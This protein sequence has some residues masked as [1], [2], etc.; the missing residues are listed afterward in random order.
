MKSRIKLTYKT[1]DDIMM[2][3]YVLGDIESD[4]S[5]LILDALGNP[6]DYAIDRIGPMTYAVSIEGCKG[7]VT[8]LVPVGEYEA[9]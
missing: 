2:L 9:Y 8:A 6:D 4:L 1:D 7:V 3:G 5:A